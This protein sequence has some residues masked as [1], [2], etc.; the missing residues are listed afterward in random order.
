LRKFNDING[1]EHGPAAEQ[2]EAD[3]AADEARDQ[4]VDLMQTPTKG[5]NNNN[6]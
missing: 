1:Y 6:A 4:V 3:A 2:E 5:R